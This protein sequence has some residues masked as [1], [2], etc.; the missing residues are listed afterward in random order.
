[1]FINTA[2]D[3]NNINQF[4][5]HCLNHNKILL[6][7]SKLNRIKWQTSIFN[8]SNYYNYW[9]NYKDSLTKALKQQ[10]FKVKVLYNQELQGIWH[11]HVLLYAFNQ[12]FIYAITQTKEPNI[13]GLCAL[14][15]RSLGSLLFKPHIH[16]GKFQ[17]CSTNIFRS[18]NLSYNKLYGRKRLY[19]KQN[20]ELLLYEFF[21]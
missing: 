6:L 5:F 8:T 1:M 20:S 21:L 13:F 14:G 17:F 4:S 3:I 9:L 15:N 12:P 19:K 18:A 7:E 11:R 2:I 16:K 10:N